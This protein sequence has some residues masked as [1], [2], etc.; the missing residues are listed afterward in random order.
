MGPAWQC[1][2]MVGTGSEPSE[3]PSERTKW[4]GASGGARIWARRIVVAVVVVAQLTF[5]VRGY[6]S[7]HKEFA[8]QMFPESSTWQADVVRVTVDGR[9]VPVSDG[10]AG[11]RWSLLVPD[12][13]L[14]FTGTRR[15]A[16]AGLG[17]QVAFLASA[18]DWVARNTP[19]DHETRYLEAV[20]D[21]LAQHRPARDPGPAQCRAGRR[22]MTATVAADAPSAPSRVAR[23]D[24]L[25]GRPVSMRAFALLRIMI[26][27]IVLLHL[28][29]ILTDARYG[30]IYRDVFHEPY[31]SWYPEVPRGAYIGLLWLAVVAAAAM[32]VGL[33][34][35]A[36]TVAVWAV[37]TYDLLLSTTNFHN[38]RAYLVIVLAALAVAPCGRELSVDAAWRARRGRPRR[39]TEAPGWPLWLLRFEAATVYGASGLSKLLDD[40]WFSGTVTWHR[41]VLVRD[42]LEASV[43]PS[44]A[45]DALTDRPFHTVAAKV[46]I[47]TEL[48][49]ALGLCSRR[50]RYAA[51]WV[52]V[53]FHVAIQ[54]SASVEVFSYLA[55]AALVIWA[56]PATRDRTLVIDPA[57]TVHGRVAAAVRA[58]DWLARFRIEPGPVGGPLVVVD[59]DGRQLA[60]GRAGWLVASRLPLE[61]VRRPARRRRCAPRL[62]PGG[63]RVIVRRVALATTGLALAGVVTFGAVAPPEH[64]P[65]PDTTSLQT[66]AD[67]AVQWFVR[68]Q[69]DDGTWLYEYDATDGT[70]TDDYN[71]VRHA[72]AIMGLYQ[73]ATA[74]IDGAL[75]SADR[76]MAWA[77]DRLV[78]HDGWTALAVDGRAPV[79]GSALLVAGLA[80]RRALTGETADDE[81]LRSL[82]RFLTAQTEPSGAVVA[83][84]DAEAMAPV[85]DSRSKY[86]TG[87]AYWA[88]ARLHLAFPEDGF[89]EIADRVG[90]YLASARDDVEG[91]WPPIPDH[92]VAYGLAETVTF[93]ER[94]PDEPLTAAELAY[95][96]RQAGLFGSQVR[97]VSQQAGPWGSLVRGTRVPRGGGYGVVGEA[98][99][100]LWRVAEADDRLADVRAP[101]ADR[102]ECIAGLAT[103]VQHHDDADPKADGAWFIDGVT[104]MDDQ[105]HA[106]SALLRTEAIVETPD[107]HGHDAPSAWLWALALIATANPLFIALAVPRRRRRSERATLAALGGL[108]GAVPVVLA[109]AVSGPLLD[110]LGVSPPAVRLAVGIVGGVAGLVRMARRAPTFEDAPAGLVAALVPVAVPLVAAPAVIMLGLSAG[111]DL[112]VA[113][114]AGSMAL[115]VG[116]LTGLVRDGARRRSWSHRGRLGP[117]PR[118]ARRAS[119]PASCS[120][121]TPSST[122]DAASSTVGR[123]DGSWSARSCTWTWMRSSLPSSCAAVPSCAVD[124]SSSA[125]RVVAVSW[126]PPPTRLGDTACTR[127]CRR[128]RPVVCAPRRCSCPVT[129]PRTPRSAGTCGPSSTP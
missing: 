63:R 108:A 110:A 113:F 43:L 126:P 94:D 93:P 81:L 14:A 25:L 51:V 90:H 117:A 83:H 42:R 60:G 39:S 111:A 122:S 18:L 121:S 77:R 6:S 78:E 86:Y 24:R 29:P 72:G 10:W 26:G 54:L 82:G 69:H 66:S 48:F 99:T 76:G 58:L 98:L 37:V 5:V 105:Q 118:R 125:A 31:A 56:V 2:R 20:V 44:W 62:P 13:G 101:L 70:A 36:A 12:R 16:D 61:R 64:C 33:W 79:G 116:A 102:A 96:R 40:D 21:H 109:A 119:S 95:A 103:E 22:R 97:W 53:C 115:V 106:T 123:I 38:N 8:F 45:V 17:N 65:Q 75:A 1:L 15:H 50:T 4:L 129:T 112:G 67:A 34:T 52:A 73:A 9:R 80:E 92:W 46:V 49:I 100:G 55:I 127:R 74:G 7:A 120:S 68:N 71:L 107:G 59:R 104:R 35:R 32:T 47:A 114:V 89:G 23:I 27:P 41:L 84:Y 3:S 85:P 19:R 87:E 128:R 30:R 28:W 57:S 124:R 11:Y 91:Y 88:L